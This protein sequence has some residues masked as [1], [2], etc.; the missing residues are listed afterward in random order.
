MTISSPPKITYL[1]STYNRRDVLLDTLV[2]LD[3]TGH[4]TE[5]II[6][7]NASPD[8]TAAAVASRFPHVRLFPQTINRGPCA[9]NIGLPHARGEIILFLDDDSFPI[10]DSL[11][12][13]LVH[14]N[15]DLRLGA[16]VFTVTL[17]DGTQEC[18][19]YPDVFIGCGT[20]FRTKALRQVGGLPEDFFMQ[21]EEYDL[22][23]RLLD[24][25]W[26]VMTFSDLHVTHLKTKTAR[27]PD[28]VT[29]LDVR[30]NLTLIARHFPDEWVLPFSYDWMRRYWMIAQTKGHQQAWRRGVR[31]G[32]QRWI[33]GVE[34]KP[35]SRA[36]F[37]RFVRKHEINHAMQNLRASGVRD[38]LLIDLG[39]NSL[40]T[41][42]AAQAA[43]LS[44]IAIADQNLGNRGFTYRGVPIIT[45]DDARH[46]R[47]DAAVINNLSPV[48]VTSRLALWKTLT[49]RPAIDPVRGD[50]QLRRV[51]A[52][53]SLPLSP[54][55]RYPSP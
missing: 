27:Y 18:S 47:F 4:S 25:G 52:P 14:F 28:R 32:V 44:V 35:V 41:W 31:D 21:A 39:K 8:G 29:Y 36:T 37:E 38:L 33:K 51:S 54:P 5:T 16:A 50:N 40:T 49:P 43:G 26:R 34:R 55:F 17:P 22:S 42:R 15:S 48:H 7:D 30:N 2:K 19:A 11:D 45:D 12:R 20:A 23:L 1:I 10:G 53:K 9:K 6:V 24:A 46:L 13:M 3:Q